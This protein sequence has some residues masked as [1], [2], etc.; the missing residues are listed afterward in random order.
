[1][2]LGPRAER[3][4]IFSLLFGNGKVVNA[5]DAPPHQAVL[6]K[7]PVLVAVASEPA[8]AV[9]MPLIGEAHGN[10]V[11]AESPQFLDQAIIELAVPLARQEGNDLIAAA[12]EL[13][14]VPPVAVLGIG[15]RDGLRLP[16][17]PGVLCRRQLLDRGLSG[18]GR[19]G[20]ALLARSFLTAR[21]PWRRG[22]CGG[23]GRS[24]IRRDTSRSCPNRNDAA[25]R[26]PRPRRRSRQVPQD[27]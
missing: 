22:R 8:A 7:L 2:I 21:W 6:R 12:Q 27:D 3:P 19:R 4:V 14:A 5:G 13:R 25:T 1:M 11:V 20:R 24:P 26:L 15:E 10:A 17:V 9:V 16:R 18:E 23:R